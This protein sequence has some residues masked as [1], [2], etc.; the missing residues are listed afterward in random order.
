MYQ[1]LGIFGSLC[2]VL[3]LAGCLSV[4]GIPQYPKEWP[5]RVTASSRCNGI[6]GIYQD[7]AQQGQ[8]SWGT[9]SL[10]KVLLRDPP[11]DLEA[12]HVVIETPDTD[13]I[14]VSVWS[15]KNVV[16]RTQLTELSCSQGG[17]WVP[18]GANAV[19]RT[20]WTA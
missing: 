10:S 16:R 2:V 13:V 7:K 8:P 12:T 6:A 1:S 15:G 5:P 17:V 4:G 9:A 19:G 14:E 20:Y 3:V 11:D 18:F